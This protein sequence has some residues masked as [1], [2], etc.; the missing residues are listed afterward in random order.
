M[1]VSQFGTLDTIGWIFVIG[2]L[3]GALILLVL[4]MFKK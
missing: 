2:S 1:G 4:S 3:L